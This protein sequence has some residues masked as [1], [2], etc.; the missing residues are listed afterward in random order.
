VIGYRASFD[1]GVRDLFGL[2]Q[3]ALKAQMRQIAASL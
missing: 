2:C 1:H 3:P